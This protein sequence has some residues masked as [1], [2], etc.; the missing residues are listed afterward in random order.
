ME[1]LF[2]TNSVYRDVSLAEE[3]GAVVI[4][5]L[6]LNNGLLSSIDIAYQVDDADEVMI[7]LG[8]IISLSASRSTLISL[9][10][11]NRKAY[12]ILVDFKKRTGRISPT[13]TTLYND[14]ATP[15]DYN[16]S[17][18]I[19]LSPIQGKADIIL[20]KFTDD[21]N[22][23]PVLTDDNMNEISKYLTPDQLNI[24]NLSIRETVP[25]IIGGVFT[26]RLLYNAVINHSTAQYVQQKNEV[27]DIIKYAI[28]VMAEFEPPSKVWELADRMDIEVFNLLY[29]HYGGS[30][31][32]NID[33]FSK[34]GWEA[35]V[36]RNIKIPIQYGTEATEYSPEYE[37]KVKS[38]LD[39]DIYKVEKGY[40]I[41]GHMSNLLKCRYSFI[42]GFISSGQEVHLNKRSSISLKKYLEIH[43]Q[44]HLLPFSVNFL[45]SSYL[46]EYQ[47][48]KGNYG[49]LPLVMLLQWGPLNITDNDLF[50]VTALLNKDVAWLIKYSQLSARSAFMCELFASHLIE[51]DGDYSIEQLLQSKLTA[52]RDIFINGQFPYN[53][54]AIDKVL[55]F[56]A[57]HYKVYNKFILANFFYNVP[58]AVIFSSVEAFD[59]YLI[60][61]VSLSGQSDYGGF[62]VPK[63]QK[64]FIDESYMV[65]KSFLQRLYSLVNKLVKVGE[66]RDK[67]PY[68]IIAQLK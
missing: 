37:T 26:H 5:A 58:L 35:H 33:H 12:E 41:R 40:N 15:E 31:V 43:S 52:V 25:K 23:F 1:E 65:D 28:S 48:K 16:R 51:V 22:G 67:L 24:I 30:K 64:K 8:N 13:Y 50:F 27:M 56:M 47:T 42:A 39:T 44:P 7:K 21:V 20:N 9:E 61:M 10:D 11:E 45:N 32:R 59:Q 63:F 4:T 60:D 38:L 14:N 54:I 36:K 68:H 62:S 18:P 34:I 57:S 2:Y 49:I 55:L 29:L 19:N 6:S 3:N 66:V 17:T 53:R 46:I